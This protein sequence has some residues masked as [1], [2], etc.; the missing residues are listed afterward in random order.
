MSEHRA[1]G[2]GPIRLDRSENGPARRVATLWFGQVFVNT[3]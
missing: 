3:Q 2:P 1:P